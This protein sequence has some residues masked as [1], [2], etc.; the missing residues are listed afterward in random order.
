MRRPT[1]EE[2]V[3]AWRATVG[4]VEPRK[5]GTRGITRRAAYREELGYISKLKLPPWS[6]RVAAGGRISREREEDGLARESR[7]IDT[8]I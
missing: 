4:T 8:R 1:V 5:R 3:L 6:G 2:M 7:G